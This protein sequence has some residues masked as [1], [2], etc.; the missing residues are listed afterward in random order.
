MAAPLER[1]TTAPAPGLS[2]TSPS[3]TEIDDLVVVITAERTGAGVPTHTLQSGFTEIRSQPH[4]DGSTDGRLSIACQVATAAGAQSY[5]AYTSSAG[6][7]TWTGIYVIQKTTYDLSLIFRSN[8][9][10]QTTNAAPN[11]P[12]LTNLALNDYLVLATSF[13]HLGS[14]LT[15][16]P[17]APTNYTLKGDVSAADNGDVAFSVRSLTGITAE[18]PAAYADNQAPNG[19]SSITIAFGAPLAFGKLRQ[20]LFNSNFTSGS[21][22]A[23]PQ[24]VRAGSIS[25]CSFG[26]AT[27]TTP[28]VSDSQGNTWTI[29]RSH[30][31]ATSDYK[32]DI[33]WAIAGSSGANSVT[34]TVAGGAG[35]RSIAEYEGPFA[36]SPLDVVNSADGSSASASS[37]TA[38]PS[39]TGV[40]AVGYHM[41][42]EA[43]AFTSTGSW[44]VDVN[45][46]VATN[47]ANILQSQVRADTS[48]VAAT[49]TLTSGDWISL[50]TTFK[51]PA[52]AGT[53][54]PPTRRSMPAALLAA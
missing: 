5:Q 22:V 50:L 6:T 4:D 3:S 35:E 27:D 38:T 20:G 18:D 13:W 46:N 2:A 30:Y 7:D 32:T 43:N 51:P 47:G 25:I 53:S 11:P 21:A 49:A 48:A 37:G 23:F 54:L 39:V 28:T 26:R 36:A 52:V 31:D 10:T 15:L 40:L 33:W 12:A 29:G 42:A 17:T 1:G 41:V 9:V 14:D 45:G 44:I 34:V 19:S 16:T 24:N 8:V